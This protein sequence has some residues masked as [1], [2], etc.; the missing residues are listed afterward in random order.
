MYQIWYDHAVAQMPLPSSHTCFSEVAEGGTDPTV[1]Q[2]E[3]NKIQEHRWSRFCVGNPILCELTE[4]CQYSEMEA[5][6]MTSLVTKYV[7]RVSPAPGVP[8]APVLLPYPCL[9][10][11]RPGRTEVVCGRFGSPRNCTT[12]AALT[13]KL[14]ARPRKRR[15]V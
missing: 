7:T 11:L 2:S 4:F 1:D 10:Q 13:A 3:T 6:I 5:Y 8:N 15:R 12:A 14:I 9:S